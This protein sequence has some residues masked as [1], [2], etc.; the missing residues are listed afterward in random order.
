M[1]PDLTH[2]KWVRVRAEDCAT[3]LVGANPNT[4]QETIQERIN[5]IHADEQEL[6]NFHRLDLGESSQSVV[7]LSAYHEWLNELEEDV[8]FEQYDQEEQVDYLLLRNYLQRGVRRMTIER[9]R[10]S[11]MDPLVRVFSPLVSKLEARQRVDLAALEPRSVAQ[12][13]HDATLGIWNTQQGIIKGRVKVNTKATAFRAA[14]SIKK[15]RGHLE[16]FVTFFRG[17]DPAFDWWVKKPCADLLA[18]M[19]EYVIAIET[20]LAGMHPDAPDE[21]VGDPI[22]EEALLAELEGEM[23]AYTPEELIAAAN[24]QYEWCL[25]EMRRA[26]VDMGHKPGDWKS[27]LEDVKN[28]HVA[29]GEQ[30]RL[31]KSLVDEAAAYVQCHDLITVPELCKQKWRMFMMPP[32]AQKV[33]PFFLG[34]DS[35]IVSYPTADMAHDEKLMGMR[36]NNKHFSKATAFHESTVS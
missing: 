13:M 11:Q 25:K 23:I 22:G 34:G 8:P 27:A 17:Y 9:D 31:I 3:D 1:T 32:E 20:R 36:G 7:L 29:P 4:Q 10:I 28:L 5:R 24:V 16:E 12:T 6:I 2:D 30:P 19:A 18:A 15:L 26:A 21:I 35:I 33:N 14:N